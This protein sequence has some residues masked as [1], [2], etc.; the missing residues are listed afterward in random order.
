MDRQRRQNDPGA[1]RSLKQKIW[2]EFKT[3]VD[4]NKCEGTCLNSRHQ[5]YYFIPQG[6]LRRYWTDER[7]E[8]CL[9]ALAIG[10]RMHIVRDEL[11]HVLSILL[12]MSNEECSEVPEIYGLFHGQGKK[13]VKDD[14][15]PL[16]RQ[17][18]RDCF[19]D[20][21]TASSFYDT[22]FLFTPA[23]IGRDSWGNT[24]EPFEVLPLKLLGVLQMGDDCSTPHIAK[25][26]A[27]KGS[28]LSKE[29]LVIKEFPPSKAMSA[30]YQAEI[31]AY[32]TIHML[33]EADGSSLGRY[34]LD[35]KAAI[36]QGD[37][38]AIVREYAE[39]GSLQEWLGQNRIPYTPEGVRQL[40]AELVKLY[41]AV[42]SFQTLGFRG[43][44]HIRPHA[45]HPH[46]DITPANIFVVV[47]PDDGS[48]G[49]SGHRKQRISFKLG[50]LGWSRE[51]Q[52]M[53]GGTETP[54]F[55]SPRNYLAPELFDG[56]G[57]ETHVR[58]TGTHHSDL[59][60]LS[61]L[62]LEIAVWLAG[63]S[64]AATDFFQARVDENSVQRLPPASPSVVGYEGCFHD[65]RRALKA[66]RD[67]VALS[68]SNQRFFDGIT[69]KIVE[70]VLEHGLNSKPKLR[71]DA[72]ST[73]RRLQAIIDDPD[74]LVEPQYPALPPSPAPTEFEP[75]VNKL[76]VYGST[77]ERFDARVLEGAFGAV[78]LEPTV[79]AQPFK[80]T[81][82]S[83]SRRPSTATK[84]GPASAPSSPATS[85]L[86]PPSPATTEPISPTKTS[87]SSPISPATTT[88]SSPCMPYRR[89]FPPAPKHDKV[90]VDY[91]INYRSNWKWMV[92]AD[93][94]NAMRSFFADV[95]QALDGRDQIFLIDDHSTML[96]HAGQLKRTLEAIA[97]VVK[98]VDRDGMELRFA[99][100]PLA[101]HT[102]YRA[103]DLAGLLERAAPPS[104]SSSSSSSSSMAAAMHATLTAVLDKNA[105]ATPARRRHHH[106]H[107]HSPLE[108]LT[109]SYAPARPTG[110]NIYVMT[111]GV[112][113]HRE[114]RDSDVT[115]GVARV[116]R[117]F[118][119]NQQR[120]GRLD[121]HTV[122]QM[123]SFGHDEV[124]LE[125]LRR[126]DDDLWS[127][128][129]GAAGGGPHAH[130][131]IVDTKA[132]TECMWSILLGAM[133]KQ[134]D[135]RPSDARHGDGQERWHDCGP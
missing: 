133:D 39:G 110:T 78:F 34:F 105:G 119:R 130:W 67:V 30:I 40:W 115:L 6:F 52:G 104:S 21:G 62:M 31:S 61:C 107:H 126:L 91:V 14:R 108:W 90:T 134:E 26:Q 106:H 125:R 135:D 22:Q 29:L 27:Y 76:Y 113:G 25:Y 94:Y 85:T 23:S 116:I 7:L 50:D 79:L 47:H 35:C 16:S 117:G 3:W 100:D 112:W 132:H 41:R 65:G 46:H 45:A 129:E 13:R 122:I 109:S 75:D 114:R 60:S 69:G 99:S 127:A 54:Q 87:A 42:D 124:G 102:V 93:P 9:E 24:L 82:W 66:V 10:L 80:S 92:E 101:R 72:A 15:L 49:W 18:S 89:S 58:E 28:S 11:L 118:I 12:R 71:G 36:N 8:Q 97:K 57:N 81:Q 4:E 84:N 17:S 96:A 53:T 55:C 86:F 70:Y 37:R 131:D 120:S 33:G 123:V 1:N 95:K 83:S 74:N 88:A 38:A 128:E 63:G 48:L 68:K 98:S 121:T 20:T 64:Q 32:E 59:W 56:D 111:S 2:R 77:D 5:T 44:N 73:A 51:R 103:A 19:E 43:N